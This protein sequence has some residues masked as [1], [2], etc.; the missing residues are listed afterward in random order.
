MLTLLMTVCLG[1][2][3]H[4]PLGAPAELEDSADWPQHQGPARNGKAPLEGVSLM[5]RLKWSDEE[6]ESEDTKLVEA[7]VALNSYFI[8]KTL[9]KMRGEYGL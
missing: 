4:D 5:P 7:V 6:V 9:Q 1:L 8:N 2:I 3:A